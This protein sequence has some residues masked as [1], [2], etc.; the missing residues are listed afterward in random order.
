MSWVWE[1]RI[2]REYLCIDLR[3]LGLVWDINGG[4]DMRML[5]MWLQYCLVVLFVV[6]YVCC[7][8]V[9]KLFFFVLEDFEGKIFLVLELLLFEGC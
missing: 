1:L 9:L 4:C 8:W 3:I 2:L 5:I 7:F 6:L